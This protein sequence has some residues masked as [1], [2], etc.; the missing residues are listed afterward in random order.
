VT[1]ID[2]V[3]ADLRAEGDRLEE[4]LEAVDALGEEGWARAS[5]APGWSVADVVLHLAQT[6]EGVVRTL[7]RGAGTWTLR[8]GTLDDAVD[9]QVA[10]QRGSGSE[11]GRRWR[12]ARL[13]AITALRAADPDVA[14]TWAAAPLK[15]RTLATTRLAEH[16]AHALDVADALGVTLPDTARLR[17]IAWLGHATL[18]YALGLA[19]ELPF[20]VRAELVGPDGS[21]WVFGP[22]DAADR[23]SGPA[24]A[25]CRVGARRL[26]AEESGL[27]SSGPRAGLAL[28]LLRNYAA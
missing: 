7:G 18:P 9:A 26:R 12:A 22:A 13:A 14:V 28:G 21:L 23:I 25:F 17:H 24:G 2:D 15:P 20:P 3:L 19:G 8:E 16:W 11:I 10:A 1:A 4:L 27:L 6:E 5:G